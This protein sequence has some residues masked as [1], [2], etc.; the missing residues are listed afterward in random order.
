MVA[1]SA[2]GGR[3]HEELLLRLL[4]RLDAVAG[5]VQASHR[6]GQARGHAAAVKLAEVGAAGEAICARLDTLQ[7]ALA[8]AGTRHDALAARVASLEQDRRLLRVLSGGA[9]GLAGYLG[10]D[11][12]IGWLRGHP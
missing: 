11:R 8:E 7:A 12:L 1:V 3:L 10:L 4:A 9:I 2:D 5:E 6:D